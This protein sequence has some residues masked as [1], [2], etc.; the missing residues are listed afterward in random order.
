[1]ST[2]WSYHLNA[3]VCC[4]CHGITCVCNKLVNV[5]GRIG[6]CGGSGG[7]G[8]SIVAGNSI[9]ISQAP[10]FP[11]YQDYQRYLESQMQDQQALL[12]SLMGQTDFYKVKVKNKLLLLC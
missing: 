6:V 1:M 8:G 2:Y 3:E 4:S 9:T 7:G 5:D 12:Q 11:Q 10:L